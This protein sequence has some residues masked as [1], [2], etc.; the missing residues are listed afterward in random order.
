MSISFEKKK[1][2]VV[3]PRK[4]IL[5]S[6]PKVG[7]T[8]LL[9][10]LEDNFI[11]DSDVL[12]KSDGSLE[13][14][15]DFYDNISAK[16]GSFE[17]LKEVHTALLNR[18][19]RFKYITI[20]TITSLYENVVNEYAVT[21]YNKEK[22]ANKDLNWD[23]NKLDYGA[24]QLYKREAIQNIINMFASL[25]TDCLIIAGHATD[26]SVNKGDGTINT[27]DLDIEGKLKNILSLKVDAIGLLY[28]KSKNKNY[29]NF[30]TSDELMGGSRAKHLKNT[31][32]LIS[33][34]DEK[35]EYH[36]Y[37]DKVFVSK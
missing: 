19:K 20:D 1:G 12:V 10:S 18:E 33:E 7:K 13:G 27:K 24:G 34:I 6:Y 31:E 14:G 37:W 28:R 9:S 36:T 35:G 26:K 17:Q 5:F 3:N 4:L 15:T 21:M 22:G 32:F 2:E 11:I 30:M 8:E 23:I 25:C 29:L 16:V